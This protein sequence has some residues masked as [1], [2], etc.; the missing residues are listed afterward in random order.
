MGI[1]EDVQLVSADAAAA[2]FDGIDNAVDAEFG[3]E[4]EYAQ[5]GGNGMSCLRNG[6][7]FS[8]VLSTTAASAAAAVSSCRKTSGVDFSRCL[9]FLC[10]GSSICVSI[11][12]HCSF[13]S[14]LCLH[15]CRLI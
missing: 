11:F 4:R 8:A 14:V 7:G 13:V 6:A 9:C 10:L 3:S 5:V 2:V 12:S 1:E 15:L